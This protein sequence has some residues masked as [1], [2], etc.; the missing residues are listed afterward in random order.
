MAV[1]RCPLSSSDLLSAMSGNE[2]SIVFMF[3]AGIY[4]AH[5]DDTEDK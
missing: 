2:I 3:R 5:N 4:G 1:D